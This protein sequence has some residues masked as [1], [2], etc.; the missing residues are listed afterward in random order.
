M[1]ADAS[2]KS[3]E[4]VCVGAVIGARGLKGE[5]RVKSFTD[6]P[7]DLFAYGPVSDET[8]TQ[9]FEGRISGRAKDHLLVFLKGIGDRNRADDL[10]GTRF[11][12]DR[13]ALPAPADDEF[14][15]ADLIGLN[16]ELVDG[17]ELGPVRGVMDAGG[18]A[19]LEIVTGDGIVMVPFTRAAVPVVDIEGGRVVVDP[20]DGLFEEPE[21]DPEDA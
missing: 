18:G 10:K 3:P 9:I 14:Y 21:R 17:G 11:Y 8:G 15:H 13:N 4:R 16:A 7:G 2:A 6:D 1:P 5:L 20:P 12:V 19:S